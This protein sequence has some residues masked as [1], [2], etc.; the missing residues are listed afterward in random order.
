MFVLQWII[1]FGGAGGGGEVGLPY[2]KYTGVCHFLGA[3][4]QGKILKRVCQLFK[5]IPERII[6][7]ER[8]SR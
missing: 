7:S 5:K 2:E 8:N 1:A 4:F 3:H 6:M